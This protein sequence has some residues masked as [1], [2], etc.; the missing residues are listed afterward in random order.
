MAS[1]VSNLLSSSPTLSPSPKVSRA[2]DTWTV[3]PIL[4]SSSNLLTR[5]ST[6]VGHWFPDS[7]PTVETTQC[8]NDSSP[9]FA[10][11]LGAV[12]QIHISD[13]PVFQGPHTHMEV[14][15]H[16]KPMDHPSLHWGR[17]LTQDFFCG[18]LF[19]RPISSV[20]W[21]ICQLLAPMHEGQGKTPKKEAN[22]S[23]LVGDR[24]NKQGNLHTKFVLDNYKVNRAP[25]T[26]ARI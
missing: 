12:P 13:Q 2:V 3:F 24:F 1:K 20:S 17:W 22:H 6:L 4:S 15:R 14:Y 18:C 7:L 9:V 23:R 5:N 19:S 16:L 26:P 21:L 25:H 8:S 11:A 10:A